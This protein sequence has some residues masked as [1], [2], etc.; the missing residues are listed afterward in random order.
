VLFVAYGVAATVAYSAVWPVSAISDVTGL[1][2]YL[3]GDVQI[4]NWLLFAAVGV[5]LAGALRAGNALRELRRRVLWGAW[6][7]CLY[8]LYQ[9]IAYR[10]G[11]PLT[12][13]LAPQGEI[14]A[15]FDFA[16]HSYYRSTAFMG[17]PKSLGLCCVI[18]MALQLSLMDTKYGR[19]G[20][21]WARLAVVIAT[22]FATWS[23]SAWAGGALCVLIYVA[24]VVLRLNRH[25]VALLAM[26]VLAV[27]GLLV[28]QTGDQFA[29]AGTGIVSAG[30][31]RFRGRLGRGPLEDFVEVI[32][33]QILTDNP[34]FVLTGC[35]LGGISFYIAQELGSTQQEVVLAP[36]NGLLSWISQVGVVGLLLLLVSV[37]PGIRG[38][39]FGTSPPQ[40]RAC[41]FVGLVCLMQMF[42]FS[43]GFYVFSVACGFLLA[44]YSRGRPERIQRSARFASANGSRTTP[45]SPRVAPLVGRLDRR[46]PAM[47]RSSAIVD[48]QV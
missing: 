1:H 40:Q 16:G 44:A 39:I 37:W 34:L 48:V 32:S 3:R 46:L 9:Q 13:I 38:L 22:L 4:A 26:S 25:R 43:G 45:S 21:E 10:T 12:G 31:E 8:A 36:N 5:I 23:T 6:P 28:A 35:G 7:L 19:R 33:A 11:L 29:E 41:A 27:L 30:N 47:V 20:R 17:E 14:F 24:T 42:I 18:Y 2:S 15:T